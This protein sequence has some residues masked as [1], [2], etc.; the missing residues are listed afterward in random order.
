MSCTRI[1]EDLL[2]VMDG[3]ARED[4]LAHVADCDACRDA[5]HAALRVAREVERAADDWK[6]PP[7]LEARALERAPGDS[8]RVSHSRLRSTPP[9]PE[10]AAKP[11][12][13]AMVFTRKHILLSIAAVLGIT[14]GITTGI[15]IADWQKS[16]RAA[17]SRAWHGKV[18]K[19][20]RSGAD[21]TGGLHAR[22]LNGKDVPLADGQ[23]VKAGWHVI[24]DA[25]TR[26]RVDFERPISRSDRRR[27]PP[28]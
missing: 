10:P 26:A 5:K 8:A 15:K 2:G 24:T 21:K 4:L 19:V 11:G 13:K 14:A 20:A 7:D 12:R 3:G 6:P 9:P 27:A 28:P 25:R 22:L 18:G 23:E 16:P 17:A 1:E